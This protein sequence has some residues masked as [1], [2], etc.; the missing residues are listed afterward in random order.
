MIET[1]DIVIEENNTA[2]PYNHGWVKKSVKIFGK[3]F[4]KE[5]ELGLMV[6]KEMN[7]ET[8]APALSDYLAFLTSYKEVLID[9]YRAKNSDIIKDWFDGEMTSDWYETLEIYSGGIIFDDNGVPSG[10]FS[11]GDNMVTDHLLMV[12]FNHKEI[13]QMCF[14]G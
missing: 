6:S 1:K 14:E 5:G 4:F 11:C 3:D 7:I 2:N 9:F 8:L 13:C 10:H 12:E